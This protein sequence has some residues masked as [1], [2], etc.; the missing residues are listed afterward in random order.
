MRGFLA[1]VLVLSCCGGTP[2]AGTD[3]GQD[4]GP[5]P[6][7]VTE[8]SE[9]FVPAMCARQ[10]DC[11]GMDARDWCRVDMPQLCEYFW[12]CA[13]TVPDS[14]GCLD[15]LRVLPCIDLQEGRWPATCDGACE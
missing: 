1:L 11:F 15:A 2:T 4:G 7:T 5:L 12:W 14:K 3:G 13:D 10:L 6:V 8:H 9:A